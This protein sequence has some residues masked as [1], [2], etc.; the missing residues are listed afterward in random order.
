MTGKPARQLRT[1]WTEAWEQ[2][3]SPDPL[4]M[5]LQGLLYAEAASRFSR[6]HAKEFGGSPAGQIL[7]SV[8]RVRPAREVV[9]DMVDG[10]INTVEGMRALADGE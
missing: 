4:P 8:D 7:G 9:L 5:P 1:A 3:G 2:P 10:W 6:V